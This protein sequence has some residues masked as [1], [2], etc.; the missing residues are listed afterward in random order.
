MAWLQANFAVL[1]FGLAGLFAKWIGLEALQI[2]FGRVFFSSITLGTLLIITKKDLHFHSKKDACLFGI[3]GIILAFHWWAFLQSIQ[4]SSIA[5]GT[6]T[7]ATFPLFVTI[8]NAIKEKRQPTLRELTLMIG[9]VV[10]AMVTL[11]K[12]DIDS[13]YFPGFIVG[14]ASSFAYALL[15]ML[16]QSFSFHYSAMHISFY[17]QAVATLILLP[18]MLTYRH[19]PTIQDLE[20]LLLL[21]VLCTALAH[22]LFIASLKKIPATSAGIIS[23]LETVY[24]IVFGY[25]LLH[26]LPTINQ[27]IGAFII[28][29][30]VFIDALNKPTSK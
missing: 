12:F 2:T 20:L 16:N 24:S 18:L 7:F 29:T 14:M 5:I 27:I 19:L 3:S 22:S 13:R 28:L 23:S 15:T 30:V 21:G 10:G 8:L 1:L 9:L 26:E 25:L 11:G 17:E 6:I 4:L